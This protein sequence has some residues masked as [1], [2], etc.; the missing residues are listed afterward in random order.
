[1]LPLPKLKLPLPFRTLQ[2]HI[3]ELKLFDGLS[4][5]LSSLSLSTLLRLPLVSELTRSKK[6]ITWLVLVPAIYLTDVWLLG[7]LSAYIYDTSLNIKNLTNHIIHGNGS[8]IQK[9]NNTTWYLHH[10]LITAR[11]WLITPA[12]KLSL[13][14][15]KKIWLILNG[16]TITAIAAVYLKKKQNRNDT[17]TVHGLKTADNPAYGTT[18]WASEKDIACIAEFGPPRPGSGGVVIG[19]LK[20]KIFP[21]KIIRIIPGKNTNK[22]QLGITGHVAVFGVTGSGKSYSFVRPNMIAATCEEQSMV[23]TDP[24]GE[25]LE[26]MGA[27]LKQQG[28]QVLVFNLVDPAA[29]HRWNPIAECRNDEEIAEMAACMIENAA[30]DNQGYFV[31][32]EVQLL[33]ALAGLLKSAFPAQQAHLRAALSLASW[34]QEKLEQ[35]FAAAYQ[36]KKI[37]PTIY[38]RWRGASAKNLDSAISGLTAKLKIIT[39]RGLA[40]LM[41]EHEIDLESIGKQKTVCILILPVK[42]SS[43]LKPILSVFYLFMFNRLYDLAAQNGGKLPVPVR[44]ILDEFANVGKI[45]G[46][47]EKISTARSLG[48]LL[49]YILQG[50]SQLD[51]VYG[52]H[53]AH[54]IMANTP[55]SLLLGVAPTDFVTMEMFSNSLGEAAVYI[56]QHKKDIATP[57]QYLDLT[58]KT[59]QIAKRRLMEKYELR[60]IPTNQC[61]AVIQGQKPLYMEKVPWTDIPQAGAIKKAGLLAVHEIVPPR[62][63]DVNLPAEKQEAQSLQAFTT[64]STTTVTTALDEAETR[65]EAT[66]APLLARARKMYNTAAAAPTMTPTGPEVVHAASETT[67]P[68][69]GSKTDNQGTSPKRE[70]ARAN[71]GTNSTGIPGFTTEPDTDRETDDSSDTTLS[72]FKKSSIF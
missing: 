35:F 70:T 28:Y 47:A 65:T 36:Q 15:V 38:E 29:S 57:L 17:D 61:I 48:I 62:P 39:T 64:A 54:T 55:I 72:H 3:A 4:G 68:E 45:P 24:K 59:R 21:G 33:E 40:A 14:A 42:E 71:T 19:K 1:M 7:S 52:P 56:E 10:P 6:L 63:L 46:F 37:S 58:Q 13:P 31:A 32:K 22:G 9:A 69:T 41:S 30:K 23:L 11:A 67:G 5:R 2:K 43:V 8:A 27:W 53:E 25:L 12:E 50:R 26:T 49:Q 20:P 34:P 51:D 44:F 16:I 18:R 60:E 66:G